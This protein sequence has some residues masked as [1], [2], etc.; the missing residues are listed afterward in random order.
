MYTRNHQFV[1]SSSTLRN[2]IPCI[3]K[4]KLG[5][6]RHLQLY[7]V[8]NRLH[9]LHPSIFEMIKRSTIPLKKEQQKSPPYAAYT[10]KCTENIL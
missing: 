9:V 10:K 5:Y 1:Q 8:Y 7:K 3:L 6:L 2:G 4:L